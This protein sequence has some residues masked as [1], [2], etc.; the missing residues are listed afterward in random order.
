MKLENIEGWV[1]Q[2]LDPDERDGFMVGDTIDN[3]AGDSHAVIV[4]TEEP[5]EEMNP[6][7]IEELAEKL[8]VIGAFL[9]ILIQPFYGL[10]VLTP[11]KSVGDVIVNLDE[12]PEPGERFSGEAYRVA[13][14][15]PYFREPIGTYLVIGSD[16]WGETHG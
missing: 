10:G 4:V 9:S 13:E 3:L 12:A 8:P 6:T 14:H 2:R 7:T 16:E 15:K 1:I 5:A 11:A